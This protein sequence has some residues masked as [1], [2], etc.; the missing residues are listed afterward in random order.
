MGNKNPWKGILPPKDAQIWR[1]TDFTKFVS[2]L[3]KKAL[4][5]ARADT[6]GDPFEGSFPRINIKKRKD[7]FM[8]D[9]G[10][11][12]IIQSTS[13]LYRIFVRLT[14]I[15]C[16]HLNEHESDAMWKLYLKN[17][18]GIAIQSTVGRLINSLPAYQTNKIHIY[19]VEYV[20]YEKDR[21]PEGTYS[22][23]FHKRKSFEH[24][25][26]L[27]ALIQRLPLKKTGEI[28]FRKTPFVNGGI[29]VPVDLD[30]LIERIYLSPTCPSWQKDV[31]ESLIKKYGLNRNIKQSKL[32]EKPEY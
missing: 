20:N 29:Y 14:V 2:I 18:D 30:K 1:Y 12:N 27:R 5:F 9:L 13:D 16:W 23:Y 19:K 25:H 24:E 15:N 8:P 26:E 4:F 6:L 7:A 3:D 31:L 11:D 22:P 21:I 10:K 17:G 28:D 32:T